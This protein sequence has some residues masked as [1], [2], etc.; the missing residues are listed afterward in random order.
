MTA[1]SPATTLYPTTGGNIHCFKAIT[2][3][4]IFDILSPPYS[5]THGRHC[6]YYRKSP[7]RDLPGKITQTSLEHHFYNLFVFFFLSTNTT[8]IA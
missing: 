7:I 8:F 4:A 6:N 2:H 5:S 1:P 3:C